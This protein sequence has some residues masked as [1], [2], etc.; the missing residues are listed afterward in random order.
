MNDSLLDASSVIRLH[1][2]LLAAPAQ[3]AD[4]PRELLRGPVLLTDAPCPDWPLLP[5]QSPDWL[6]SLRRRLPAS[7]LL[8]PDRARMA[9]AN[10]ALCLQLSDW[11]EELH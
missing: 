11:L 10:E 6:A 5:L 8:Q 3:V 7:T 1:D 2:F 4:A 9:Q